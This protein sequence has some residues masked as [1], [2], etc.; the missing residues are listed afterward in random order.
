VGS[1]DPR[2]RLTCRPFDNP[3]V[4]SRRNIELKARDEDPE[5]S[6][7]VCRELGAVDHGVIQQLD[8][9]FNVASGCLKL[10]QETPGTAHLIQYE[11]A[12]EPQQRESRYRIVEI[13]DGAQLRAALAAALGLRVVVAKRR[14]L[15]LWRDVRIHLDQVDGL[16]AFIELEAVAPLDSDLTREHTLVDDLRAAFAI[17]DAH[18]VAQG[19]AAM[20]QGQGA[21]QANRSQIEKD[22]AE[23]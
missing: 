15:H 8:T 17:T 14:R 20:L 13:E 22:L 18:L 2:V 16:G 9:H 19:Y 7:E 1:Y 21:P 6:L 5:R 3:A 23:W 11:R 12:D 10:R 4:D